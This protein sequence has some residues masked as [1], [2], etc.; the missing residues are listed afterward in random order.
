MWLKRKSRCEKVGFE[1]RFYQSEV[2]VVPYDWR[3]KVPELESRA[4]GSWA[5]HGAEV[6][7]GHR[8]VDGGRG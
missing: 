6:S 1:E 8:Q 7:G 2:A 3:E 4:A 5:P